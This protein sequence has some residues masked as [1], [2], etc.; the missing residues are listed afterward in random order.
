MKAETG[1]LQRSFGEIRLFPESLDDLWHLSHLV[2]PG[3]LVFATTLRSVETPPDRIRPEKAE[4]RPV[5]LGIRVGKVEFH[6]FANRLRIHGVI[7][8]GPETGAHH[9][10]N[11]EP[12][13]EISVIK[14]WRQVELE[15]VDRAVRTSIYEAVHILAIEEGDAELFRIRQF[16]PEGVLSCTAGSGKESGLGTRQDFFARVASHLSSITGPLVV[17][18]PGF[19]KE[20][21]MRYLQSMLP[22]VAARCIV[23]ET[24]R[25]GS[26]AVQEVIGQGV[27]ER[28]H[29]D[30]QLGN[31]VRTI[32]E[33]LG[34]IGKGLPAAYGR[35]EVQRAVDYGACERLLVLDSLLRDEGIVHLIDRAELMNAAIVVFSSEFEPGKQLEGLGGIAALLR[36]AVE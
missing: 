10:L 36:Y 21:F 31:E 15:R 28:I 3:D 30:L 25:I 4:K 26:G 33:L 22:G 16:G 8:Q 12:G 13:Y 32:N 18:G 23:V 20:D 6:K 5:R 19:V 7:E 35:A 29:E 2:G 9:T 14:R 34:R 11:I 17:A 24:R 27:L 1:E